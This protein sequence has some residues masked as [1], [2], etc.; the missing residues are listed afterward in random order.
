MKCL[1]TYNHPCKY[2]NTKVLQILSEVF[3]WKD[4]TSSNSSPTIPSTKDHAILTFQDLDKGM[5]RSIH[6]LIYKTGNIHILICI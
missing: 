5:D 6:F 1:P 4:K 3:K 2:T